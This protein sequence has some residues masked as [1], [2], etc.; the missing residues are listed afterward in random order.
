MELL[1]TE[2]EAGRASVNITAINSDIQQLIEMVM[3]IV[4]DYQ[5]GS[6][7]VENMLDWQ[8]FEGIF[9]RLGTSIGER[10]MNM[11]QLW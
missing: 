8:S 3:Q 5:S 10:L 9:D 4:T 6:R 2:V 7:S 11:S 1:F